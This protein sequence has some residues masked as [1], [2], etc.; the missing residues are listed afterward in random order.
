[1]LKKVTNRIWVW[2]MLEA[3]L[4]QGRGYAVALIL[5]TAEEVCS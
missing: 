2:S 3:K 5:P 4:N 1:M